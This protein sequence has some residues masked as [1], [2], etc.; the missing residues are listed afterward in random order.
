MSIGAVLKKTL[1]KRSGNPSDS[2][3]G[4]L[5]QDGFGRSVVPLSIYLKKYRTS[6]H[7]KVGFFYLDRIQHKD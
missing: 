4:R 5:Y 7:H 1:I 3:Q 6:N 2:L